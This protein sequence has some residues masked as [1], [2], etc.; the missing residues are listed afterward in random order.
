MA[1]AF[2]LDHRQSAAESAVAATVES[3]NSG[4]GDG[5]YALTGGFLRACGHRPQQIADGWSLR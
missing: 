1:A 3:V 2:A 5:P 4:L